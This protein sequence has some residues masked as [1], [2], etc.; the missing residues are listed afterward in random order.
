MECT[1]FLFDDCYGTEL[2]TVTIC[3]FI[4]A[5]EKRLGL[6]RSDLH[7]QLKINFSAVYEL[8]IIDK[9]KNGTERQKQT[10]I[11]PGIKYK[12]KKQ[13]SPCDFN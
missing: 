13:K 3:C 8:N 6:Y 11:N 4:A 5:Q 9:L 10:E 12:V 1:Y 7:N 2:V